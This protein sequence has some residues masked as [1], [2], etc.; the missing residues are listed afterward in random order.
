MGAL[1]FK[2]SGRLEESRQWVRF[3]YTPV[4]RPALDSKDN[5]EF[6]PAGIIESFAERSRSMTTEQTP[7][8]PD[9]S[10]QLRRQARRRSHF[11]PGAGFA[12]LGHRGLAWIGT[13]TI[14]LMPATFLCLAFTFR[15]FLFWS[16]LASLVIYLCFYLVEQVACRSVAIYSGGERR[17][18]SR[19]LIPVCAA[20][21]IGLIGVLVICLLNL[22]S[23]RI[24]GQGMMPTLL[25][26]DLLVYRRHVFPENLRP[27]HLIFFRPSADSAWGN[28]GDLVVARILAIPGVF[29]LS[30]IWKNAPIGLA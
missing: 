25:S 15:A 7:R 10:E 9:F 14:A 27:R 5:V 11:W 18:L 20:G 13:A 22:G 4:S 29:C 2:T 12:L 1:V 24:G 23:M 8:N 17:F 3:P 6:Q 26:G 28:G 19:F 30:R 21:Y 16:F